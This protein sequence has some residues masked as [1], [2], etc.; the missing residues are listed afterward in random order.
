MMYDPEYMDDSGGLADDDVRICTK[1]LNLAFPHH[2]KCLFKKGH[3]YC[4][5]E[6]E[7]QRKCSAYQCYVQPFDEY[8]KGRREPDGAYKFYSDQFIEEVQ[9]NKHLEVQK[10]IMEYGKNKGY[11]SDIEDNYEI[12]DVTSLLEYPKI[13]KE[14]KLENDQNLYDK[15]TNKKIVEK[16]KTNV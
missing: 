3:P 8:D 13:N 9:K 5:C 11:S 1:T 16:I 10:M 14:I 6:S 2:E 7:E 12:E 15:Y 4:D